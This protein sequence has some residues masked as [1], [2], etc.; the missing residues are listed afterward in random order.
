MACPQALDRM[1][2]LFQERGREPLHPVFQGTQEEASD[3]SQLAWEQQT[4]WLE[5]CVRILRAFHLF[6]WDPKPG[7]LQ[8]LDVTFSMWALEATPDAALLGRLLQL[9]AAFSYC[10]GVFQDP[11]RPA[12]PTHA[13]WTQVDACWTRDMCAGFTS[14]KQHSG[15]GRDSW[16]G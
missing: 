13:C 9:F 1:A 2:E 10:P 7:F 3:P 12:L 11:T 15:C 5:G 14:A 8:A 16:R 4:A 6:G